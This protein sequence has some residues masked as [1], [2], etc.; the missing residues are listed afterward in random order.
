MKHSNKANLKL[1]IFFL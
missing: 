1:W